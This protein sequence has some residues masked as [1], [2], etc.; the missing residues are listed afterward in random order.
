[1]KSSHKKKNRNNAAYLF[2]LPFIIVFLIFSVYPVLRTLYL[3]FTDLKVMGDA[4]IIGFANYKR[5]VLDK[6]FWISLW[7]MASMISRVAS[8]KVS[9]EV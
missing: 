5:V 8:F 1:M 6:F 9:S 7:L 3:S 2:V 4:H